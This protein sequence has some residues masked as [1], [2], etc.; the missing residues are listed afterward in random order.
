M[1]DGTVG[2]FVHVSI[3]YTRPKNENTPLRDEELKPSAGVIGKDTLYTV[4]VV[5][6]TMTTMRVRFHY[7]ENSFVEK[8]EGDGEMHRSVEVIAV[9]T[10]G[11][12]SSRQGPPRASSSELD[13]DHF[14]SGGRLDRSLCGLRIHRKISTPL[15]RPMC[16]A[17]TSTFV[18]VICDANEEGH[19]N[20]RQALSRED[21]DEELRCTR[22]HVAV[23]WNGYCKD[24]E[25]ETPTDGGKCG[26]VDKRIGSILFQ[27]HDVVAF[28]D[29]MV[30]V[31]SVCC[32]GRE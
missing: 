12:S 3:A 8:T 14:S 19:Q 26:S 5:V 23:Q 13:D 11:A 28:H 2:L 16:D 29:F 15:R 18:Q 9:S 20:D 31:F 17:Q 10:G 1:V 32:I 24:D 21:G 25:P 27:N 7:L 30:R 6:V 4:V 22:K